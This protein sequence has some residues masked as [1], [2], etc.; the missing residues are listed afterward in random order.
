ME[1]TITVRGTGKASVKPDLI[2]V[3]LTLRMKD[4]VYAEAMTRS[5][6]QQEALRA[7][8]GTAGF[9]R[10]AL[11]TGSFNVYP[12][13]ES[14][15]DQK[16]MFRQEFTGYVCEHQM[17]LEFDFDTE[18][19]S[20]ALT[21]IA[22][23]VADPELNVSFTVKDREALS[24]ALLA[25]AAKNARARAELLAGASGVKL[26]QLLTID[27]NWSEVSFYSPTNYRAKMSVAACVD[28]SVDMDID[29]QNIDLSDSATFVW[30]I[31]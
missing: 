14:V 25:S 6:K 17:Y 27:Y 16:G 8:L 12:E 31:E 22:F 15:R 21:A 2:R 4:K 5:S 18:L 26:G 3:S 23:C 19:L 24:D 9:E 30:E 13:Y 20:R 11:K 28:E 10:E 1:R 7:A 29:P